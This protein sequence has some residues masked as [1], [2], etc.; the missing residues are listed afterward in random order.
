MLTLALNTP[1]LDEKVDE[2]YEGD[3]LLWR[4]QQLF[5]S[6][7][8]RDT[9]YEGLCPKTVY[10]LTLT[11]T[12]RPATDIEEEATI[13]EGDTLLWRCQLIGAAGTYR[14]TVKYQGSNAD[15]LRYTLT[16]ALKTPEL[17]E[18][19]DVIYE[20]D[21]L[22]WR[23]M[24][25]AESGVYRDT[26]YEDRCPQTIYKLT[27]TVIARVEPV[28]IKDSI[29]L[30]ADDTLLWRCRLIDKAG[31]Y[32]DTVFFNHTHID[33]VRYTMMVSKRSL[34]IKPV[35]EIVINKGESKEWH[36]QV[37]KDAGE[38]TYTEPYPTAP[39]CDSVEYRLRLITYDSIVH[40]ACGPDT[41]LWRC[42][43]VTK[44]GHYK[45][46][47]HYT[48]SR[49]TDTQVDS[50]YYVLQYESYPDAFRDTLTKVISSVDTPYVWRGD[51]YYETGF[52]R[53]SIFGNYTEC[54]DTIY[55]LDL[56]V[57]E[58]IV[59]ER[60]DTI[61]LGDTL[62]WGC[63]LHSASGDF[64]QIFQYKSGNDSA[65]LILHLTRLDSIVAPVEQV[66]LP[67]GDSLQWVDGEWYKD[68]GEYTYQSHYPEP[69][70]CD[71]V[72]HRMRI[73][74]YDSTVFHSC[75]GDTLLWGCQLL[76]EDGI[77]YD[78]LRQKSIFTDEDV[79][80]V[81]SV[82]N[83]K[84]LRAPYD[85]IQDLTISQAVVPYMWR[86]QS[87]TVSGTYYDTLYFA[88]SECADTLYT[89]NL[90]VQEIANIEMFDTICGGDTLL[91]QCN[92]LSDSGT[93]N[94]T[95][96]YAGTGN[97]S[98][99]YVMHLTVHKDSIA[100]LVKDTLCNNDSIFFGGKWLKE[101][102]LY[103]DTLRYAPTQFQ[104][105]HGLPGCDSLIR[106]LD[107][108][109]RKVDSLHTD[110]TICEA[111]T[112]MWRNK[113]WPV[114]ELTPTFELFD[115]ARYVGTTDCDTMRYKLTVNVLGKFYQTTD[116]TVCDQDVINF[117]WKPYNTDFTNFTES[118]T[119]YD[120]ARYVPVGDQTRGCDSVIYILNLRVL[121][122]LLDT[123]PTD[124]VICHDA[125][126]EWFGQIYNEAGYYT[127]T[128]YYP[129]TNCD[130]AY[131]S[132]RLA[133]RESPKTIEDNEL[134]ICAGSEIG[135]RSKV[136]SEPGEHWD[137]VYY[138]GTECDSLYCKV[139]LVVLSPTYDTL[140]A[141]Y[142]Q[143]GT[144]YWRG[145][146]LENE[147]E[148]Y[149]TLHYS[150]FQQCDSM[151][152]MLDLKALVPLQIEDTHKICNGETYPWFDQI[153]TQPGTYTHTVK[154]VSGCDSAYYTLHLEKQDPLERRVDS[155]YICGSGQ[156]EWDLNH[157]IYTHDGIYYD[158][159][160][161]AQGCDSIAGELHVETQ[162]S[163]TA[164]PEAASIYEGEQLLWHGKYFTEAGTYP[165][166]TFYPSGCDSVY[167]TLV[168]TVMPVG[169]VE[170]TV[171]DTV[172]AGTTYN[173][174]MINAHT[175]WTDSVRAYDK[176]GVLLD[177]ITYYI[178]DVYVFDFPEG[179]LESA[180]IACGQAPKI[181]AVVNALEAYMEEEGAFAPNTTF[182]WFISEN[183]DIWQPLDTMQALN[184]NDSI[185]SLR[186]VMTGE[187]GTIVKEATFTVGRAVY[188]ETF[189]EYDFLPVI[190]K[191]EGAML[192]I[193]V[194]AIC[195]RFGWINCSPLLSTDPSY[196][197]NGLYP[198]Q[199]HW[200]K[201]V[202]QVDNLSHP[203]STDPKDLNLNTYG[204]YFRPETDD[205]YYAIIAHELTIAI[206]D[207]DAW[208]RTVSISGGSSTV[209]DLQPN[210]VSGAQHTT[211]TVRG[212]S[213]CDVTVTNVYGN[214]VLSL[215]NAAGAFTAPTIAGT[216]FVRIK[217]LT[218]GVVFNR[219]L[220]VY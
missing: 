55:N 117:H 212:V 133:V 158:T 91:W 150:A 213:L 79:E 96:H 142:C 129:G 2:I 89:L 131:Y 36:G 156:V 13:C 1:T 83:F 48:H 183:N 123:I 181:T 214:V 144:Y 62:L 109:V 88:D 87:L 25:L 141:T 52:Y 192:M 10:Q 217:D 113:E 5:K 204:Y 182:S 49:F 118:T 153:L 149:D 170:T 134:T 136:I 138:K 106:H 72:L 28:D 220:L 22:L 189:T 16:L 57:E 166:T 63:E 73:V 132:L 111:A 152:Y 77:Y 100:P 46:I 116:T 8:Y 39:N 35:E 6:G 45:E 65:H 76:G 3:T 179:T 80:M 51:K 174:H 135:W 147:G 143:G 30:C 115:T 92:L 14:D 82:L 12:P 108:F 184:G 176:S 187:C 58:M 200:F 37:Y 140:H 56:T 69:Y 31:T 159:I 155:L 27:L 54:P 61:C 146:I 24:P 38:Y 120:T 66:I 185:V 128:K 81:Y 42:N 209:G 137:T 114:P 202:G 219:T 33:S 112:I 50:A 43:L 195:E 93:Y 44:T 122:P 208:A 157:K 160:R 67:A 177:Q 168:L 32:Y 68:A 175:E 172:C 64:D 105:E 20:G 215:Q 198:D 74:L 98:V 127:H 126:L 211:V 151:I 21:T 40:Y 34:K 173:G 210:V 171:T 85:S 216:Y 99:R 180:D 165:D 130:S 125:K 148:Y 90:T 124:T 206:S 47:V 17:V 188:P 71:S 193:D 194:D 75:Y 19:E 190:K 103:S 18:K 29:A 101:T 154:Y 199:V 139:N 161:T 201:Q 110:T 41:L 7:V 23:C 167:Y 9:V 94:E 59:D 84:R 53:D 97:D 197:A 218:S 203:D 178:I 163:S 121:K 164:D 4:C 191:F 95:L 196:T 86:E 104:T 107:L 207:C 169:R 26:V 162:R 15:S 70:G 205:S 145:K 102:G 78:T 60:W 11:V 119:M 186:V